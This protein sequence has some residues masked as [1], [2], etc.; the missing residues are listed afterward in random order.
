MLVETASLFLAARLLHEHSESP[1]HRLQR[2]PGLGLDNVRLR[3]VLA[4]IEDHLTEEIT[5]SDLASIACLSVFHFTRAFAASTGAPP[6]CY[7]K[8]RRLERAKKLLTAGK[9]SLSEIAFDCQF[10]SQSSFTRAFRRAT[11]VTPA[12]YK[13]TIR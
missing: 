7:V 13:R 10:S 3:R 11:G 4:Y 8:G 9:L 2:E 5:V 12:T 1:L 6:H